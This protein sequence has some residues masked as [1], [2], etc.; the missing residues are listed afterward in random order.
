[1]NDR[2]NDENLVQNDK[3]KRRSWFQRTFSTMLPGNM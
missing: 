3:T 1:M 2:D